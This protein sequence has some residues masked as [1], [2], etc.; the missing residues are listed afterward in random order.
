M[1]EGE[2][3]MI[4]D[5]KEQLVLKQ[6]P[7]QL[8]SMENYKER[9]FETEVEI[10]Q[11]TFAATLEEVRIAIEME[12]FP[13]L[14]SQGSSGSYF[15]R[16]RS[17]KIIGVFKPKNEE[18]YGDLNP[19]W[20]KWFQRNLCPCCFGRSCLIPNSG[21][22]SEAA[23]SVVDRF[24]NLNLVPRTE[25]VQ[26]SSKT[27]NYSFWQRRQ[28]KKGKYPLKIGSFQLFV[29]GYKDA[30]SC[31]Q[32]LI[33]D[34][35]DDSLK[36]S[37]RLQFEKL[38]ILDYIIRNTDRGHQNWMIKF[39]PESQPSRIILAAIDHGLAFPYKH[40]DN[41][42]NYPFGWASIPAAY[43]PF[44]DETARVI[45]EKLEEPDFVDAL[46]TEIRK[47]YQL[48]L[49][50][51]E[52]RFQRQMAVM[53]GQIYNLTDVLKKRKTPA[54]LVEMTPILITQVEKKKGYRRWIFGIRERAPTFKSC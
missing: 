13:T 12:V 34:P 46:A 37:F 16:D 23:A 48:D 33:E 11:A 42:R 2:S 54:E 26:L 5:S 24:L 51:N 40:P 3:I 20:G 9:I 35:L 27:F 14:I 8:I 15:C 45:L 18:P 43:V 52:A 7:S 31:F 1:M 28:A 25:I 41:W 36:N 30:E 50:F 49:H 10:D 6:E 39:D 19:K 22:L 4:S 38:V 47:I 44:S 21:Y 17:G 53:R 29:T 32:R